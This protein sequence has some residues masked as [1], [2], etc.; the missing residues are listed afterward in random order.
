MRK[1]LALLGDPTVPVKGIKSPLRGFDHQVEL[2]SELKYPIS[3]LLAT[4]S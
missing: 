1:Y 3:F 2:Y 4:I